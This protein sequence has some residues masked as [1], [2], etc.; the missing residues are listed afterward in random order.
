MT[1]DSLWILFRITNLDEE[2]LHSFAT[3]SNHVPYWVHIP[4]FLNI[5]YVFGMLLYMNI[6]VE[7]NS[8]HY[9]YNIAGEF[10]I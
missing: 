8:K 10:G 2:K 5:T 6:W 9:L 7:Q 3:L 1:E 4:V